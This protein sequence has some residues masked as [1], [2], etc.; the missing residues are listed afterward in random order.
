MLWFTWIL[1]QW[2]DWFYNIITPKNNIG[3]RRKI[4]IKSFHVLSPLF[5]LQT[6]RK[7]YQ[8]GVR[9]RFAKDSKTINTAESRIWLKEESNSFE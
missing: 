9:Y 7:F 3:I 6:E 1:W 5:L 4:K 2:F 8:I